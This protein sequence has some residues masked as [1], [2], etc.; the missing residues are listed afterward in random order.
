[1]RMSQRKGTKLRKQKV[2]LSDKSLQIDQD[3]TLTK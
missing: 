3:Q 1:M 2:W